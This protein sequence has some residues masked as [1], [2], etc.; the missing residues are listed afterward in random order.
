MTESHLPSLYNI[1]LNSAGSW[2]MTTDNIVEN[3]NIFL[4]SLNYYPES[5][6]VLV[7]LSHAAGA[8][9]PNPTVMISSLELLWYVFYIWAKVHWNMTMKQY[10]CQSLCA[11]IWLFHCKRFANVYSYW[12]TKDRL[13]KKQLYFSNHTCNLQRVLFWIHLHIVCLS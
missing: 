12:Q 9:S 4:K 2:Y 6:I 7:K 13:G 5:N 3:K 11:I 8:R 1:M 10:A